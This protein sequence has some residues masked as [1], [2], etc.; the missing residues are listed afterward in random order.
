MDVLVFECRE[1]SKYAFF[2][3]TDPKLSESIIVKLE[4]CHNFKFS[5]TKEGF[6]IR[7][8]SNSLPF[9]TLHAEIIQTCKEHGFK[10]T[11]FSIHSN[12]IRYSIF[13]REQ[14]EQKEN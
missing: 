5:K 12:D 3:P 2:S 7:N 13:E 4:E 10:L 6:Y 1:V 14:K 8:L 11:H 9:P